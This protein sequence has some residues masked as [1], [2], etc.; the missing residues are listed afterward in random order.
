MKKI[1]LGL[2]ILVS[3]SFSAEDMC[4]GLYN[5]GDY[6]KAGDC[7]IKQVKTN[8]SYDN[9]YFAG[10]SLLNQGRYKEALAYMQ[11]LE[12]LSTNEY[13]L[14]VAYNKLS[15]IYSHIGDRELEFAYDMKFLN[16]SLKKGDKKI[17]GD[18]YSSLGVY[19]SNMNDF[20]KALEYYFK[21][22]DYYPENSKYTIYDNIALLYEKLKDYNK[23]REFYYKSIESSIKVGDFLSLCSAKS[24]LGIFEYKLN[25]YLEADKVL[26]DANTICHNAGNISTEANSFIVLG[27]SSLERNDL[28]SAKSYYFQA[29]PLVNKSGSKTIL[30]NIK[31]LENK[32]ASYK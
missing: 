15:M 1:L 5:A 27:L 31:V 25:N 19:Y 14:L 30:E 29:K 9:N 20:N 3:L 26:K 4:I 18:A 11:K 32:I 22:L 16:L 7:Y 28:Q 8:N 21:S 2:S 6:K 24:N 13:D 23:A 12:Q 10:D 17:I